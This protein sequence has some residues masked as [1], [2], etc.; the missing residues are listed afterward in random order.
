[1]IAIVAGMIG[2]V[3]AAFGAILATPGVLVLWV[4]CLVLIVIG[5][6]LEGRWAQRQAQREALE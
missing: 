6:V 5:F 1:V 4:P 3:A 2:F